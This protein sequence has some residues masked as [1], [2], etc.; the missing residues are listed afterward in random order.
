MYGTIFSQMVKIPLGKAWIQIHLFKLLKII[1]IEFEGIKFTSNLKHY[2]YIKAQTRII[3][4]V[5]VT[6]E[7]KL[8]NQ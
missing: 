3:I 7:L 4:L 2:I 6:T 8:L 5:E 1:Q